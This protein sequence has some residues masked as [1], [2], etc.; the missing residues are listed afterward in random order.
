MATILS[1]IVGLFAKPKPAPKPRGQRMYAGAKGGRLMF[2]APT[3]SA[4]AELSSSLKTLRDRARALCRDVVYAKRA[5]TVVVNNVIGPG[6]GL[7]A[8]VMNR[9]KRLLQDVNDAIEDAWRDWGRAETC[10]TGG[11][12]AFADFERAAMGEVFEAGEV[13]IR[14]HY[15]PF[16]NGTIPLALELIEAERIADDHEIS[17]PPGTR[18]SMGIEHDAFGRPLAYYVYTRHPNELRQ[19]PG[20][21]ANEIMRVPAEQIIHL[22]VIERWPQARGVPWLHAAIQR[23][24]QL[25]EFEEAAVINARIGASKVGFFENPEGDPNALQDGEEA[26]GT[27]NTTVEAGEFTTLPPGYKFNS[28]DPAYPN[29]AFEPFTRACLRGIAAGVGPSYESLSRDYSQS[30]YSSSRLALLDDRDLWRV[31]QQWWIRAFREPLHRDWMQAAVLSRAIAAID[32]QD[33]LVDRKKFEAVKFKPRGWSWIDPSKDVDSFKE[34]EKAGYTTKSRIIA[35][36]GDGLD[37]EDILRERR[38][39]LDMMDELGL[40]SDTTSPAAADPAPTD[41]K[42]KPDDDTETDDEAP[43]ARVLAFNKRDHE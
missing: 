8:Q 3:S 11:R 27:P 40:T 29:D 41:P 4:D 25:G 1:R 42:P 38:R 14:K 20:T 39:E 9:R 28:W 37:L 12:L 36:T 33:Y 10:H 5:R 32:V 24:N 18:I 30:N 15:A 22:G 26:D 43:P 19:Q 21:R 2:S 16:G 7:Q 34:A 35:A 23:L 6:V 17:A 13:F 31:M